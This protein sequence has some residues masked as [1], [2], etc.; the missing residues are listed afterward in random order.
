MKLY[1]AQILCWFFNTPY[2]SLE[3]AY[4]MSKQIQNIKKARNGLKRQISPDVQHLVECRRDLQREGNFLLV[5]N[6]DVVFPCG[7]VQSS[8]QFPPCWKLS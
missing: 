2:R 8:P 5:E 3:R 6:E 7:C 1:W 4:E